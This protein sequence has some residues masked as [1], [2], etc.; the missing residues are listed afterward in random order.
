MISEA[1]EQELMNKAVQA[2]EAAGVPTMPRDEAGAYLTSV[3]TSA[4]ALLRSDEGDE[5]VRG[6]LQ[7]AH[8]DLINPPA[9]EIR[10][11]S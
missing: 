4:Y 1:R 8:D 3:M 6:W 10:K 9:F 5:Y 11:P 7:S 2:L